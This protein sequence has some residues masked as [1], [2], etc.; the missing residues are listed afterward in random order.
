MKAQERRAQAQARRLALEARRRELQL[1]R[2][3]RLKVEAI[4]L[5]RRIEAALA[6]GEAMATRRTPRQRL[7]Y[8]RVQR[9]ERENPAG[10]RAHRRVH[11]ALQAGR[12]ERPNKCDDCGLE[13]RLEAHHEDYAQP[14]WVRWLCHS[15]HRRRHGRD[16]GQGDAG[17]PADPSSRA[18]SHEGAR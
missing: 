6:R 13:R 11:L 17:Q 5:E 14:L 7:T 1:A 10:R 4:M 15:C 16:Q 18:S 8:E 12:L 9:W 2:A 3:L